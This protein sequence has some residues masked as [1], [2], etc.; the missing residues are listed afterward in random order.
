MRLG[1]IYGHATKSNAALLKCKFAEAGWEL[2]DH[3][4]LFGHL[5]KMAGGG[6]ENTTAA[7]VAKL[8]LRSQRKGLLPD[9]D[10]CPEK[11]SLA[12]QIG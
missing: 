7:V 1:L 2:F 5:K 11:L 10:P 6:Y 12:A 3:D 9:R 8:L 4:W